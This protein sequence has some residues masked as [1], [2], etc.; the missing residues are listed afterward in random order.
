MKILFLTRFGPQGA[1]S[2]LR[3]IQ[4]LPWFE[5]A[6]IQCVISSLFDDPMLLHKYKIGHYS[7]WEVL[8]AYKR[9]VQS[10]LLSHNFDLIWIEKE[11]LPWF[12]AWFEKWLLRKVPYVLDFDDAIFHNYDLHPSAWIRYFFGSRIDRLMAGAQVITAGNGYLAA[13]AAAAG[14]R[15]VVVVPTV[16]DLVRYIP[17]AM[18]VTTP[19]P[20]V[21]WIGSPSSAQ[22]L[23][24]LAQPLAALAL[25]SP[26]T[27][28]VI[29]G[30]DVSMPGVD[31][32][33]LPWSAES[34]AAL[35]A[36]CDVGIMPLRDTPWEQGKCAYK[37][38]QYMACALPV[39]ASPVGANLDVVVTGETGYFAESAGDWIEK[40]HL[41]L[42]DAPLRQR[43][44][45]A[46]RVRVA[47]HYCLQ[48]AAPLLLQLFRAMERQ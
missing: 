36:A 1:S 44:G 38:I 15:Q 47:D 25:L 8:S 37:L 11:A 5:A 43:L 33:V 32:E 22:Y 30:G 28:R 7:V 34:E 39:V 31:T 35:I 23:L 3:S 21:V 26:F 24:E 2:R 16:L 27:L 13:R 6:G 29:G 40:L 14:A 10:L 19:K 12:P 46:G 48:R 42:S 20:I 4:Y 17:K 9:R 41:L 45:S 18:H